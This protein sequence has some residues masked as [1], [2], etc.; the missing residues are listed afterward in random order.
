MR[1]NR[2]QVDILAYEIVKELRESRMI[3]VG[4]KDVPRV[5]EHLRIVIT[6]DLRVEDDLNEEV[7]QIL[8]PYLREMKATDASYSEMFKKVKA[9]LARERKIIL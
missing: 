9:K 4:E 7:R 8:E 3:E 6:A 2:H 1:L 5:E